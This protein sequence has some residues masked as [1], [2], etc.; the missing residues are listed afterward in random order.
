MAESSGTP[1]ESVNNNSNFIT[2]IH[3]ATKLGGRG[4]PRRRTRRPNNNNH[5]TLV[6]ART[7][8][9][10]LKP[11]RTQFQLQGQQ[12]LC[13]VTILYEDGHVDIQKQVHIHSTWPMTIHEID[14]SETGT[15]TYH[16]DDLDSATR[17]Y[18]LGKTL[19]GNHVTR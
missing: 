4:T 12:E 7:L 16:I 9:S 17:A 11:F 1:S 18:L 2:T 5:S 15:Q 13:D 10:K 8:E 19:F 3:P 14:S 6:A